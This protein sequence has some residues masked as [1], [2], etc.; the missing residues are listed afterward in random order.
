MSP[1]SSPNI[2]ATMSLESMH[3]ITDSCTQHNLQPQQQQQQQPQQRQVATALGHLCYAAY[4]AGVCQHWTCSADLWQQAT[5][6]SFH[7]QGHGLVKGL[8]V[9][10][11]VDKQ[12][13]QEPCPAVAAVVHAACWGRGMHSYKAF[14][15]PDFAFTCIPRSSTWNFVGTRRLIMTRMTTAGRVTPVWERPIQTT[16]DITVDLRINKKNNIGEL[17][18]HR[19]PPINVAS[20]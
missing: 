6:L 9:G 16:V 2:F 13:I 3:V 4:T 5:H 17:C 20:D 19:E 10:I 8:G 1:R 15:H 12:L 18:E 14:T 11:V 7:S